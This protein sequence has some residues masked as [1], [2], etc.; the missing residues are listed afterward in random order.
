MKWI[1]WGLL[2]SISPNVFA[3]SLGCTTATEAINDSYS[4]KQGSLSVELIEQLCVCQN[5]VSFD[6]RN[7]E[8]QKKQRV[9]YKISSVYNGALAG[10]QMIWLSVNGE[11]EWAV[12]ERNF[13]LEKRSSE[14]T[15]LLQL[16]GRMVRGIVFR[17][18]FEAERTPCS[19]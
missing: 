1:F 4:S 8:T 12:G 5:R 15:E 6:L 2:S 16:R 9:I 14:S 13:T 7:K 17:A 3:F 10:D 11:G 18:D 19:N